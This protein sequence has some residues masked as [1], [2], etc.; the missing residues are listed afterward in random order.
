MNESFI[1]F[2]LY[3]IYR[4]FPPRTHRILLLW[5]SLYDT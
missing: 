4:M 5:Y 3:G 1:P 2:R